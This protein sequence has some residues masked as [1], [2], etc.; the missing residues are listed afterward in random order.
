MI[1]II[2]PNYNGAALLP[3]CLD[4]LRRQTRRDFRTLVVDDGSTDRSLALLARDYPE[5]RVLA[6][7]R[8]RGMTGA[9]NAALAAT[10]APFVVLLNNDTEA[11]PQWLERL[12]GALERFP[13]Y[14][15]AASKM[16]LFDRRDHLHSAGDF[17]R[18]D[19]VPG[20]RGVWQRDSGQYDVVEEVFGP[21]AG[22]AAYRRSALE[23]LATGGQ[24]LDEDLGMYCEDVDLNL[25]AQL[26]GRRTVYEPRAVIYHRLSATGGGSL[27][28]YYC[29]RNFMLVWA[30][31]MPAPLARRAWPALALSQIG[32]ALHSLWH[33]REKAARAR[34][35]G[36]LAG[37][38]ALPRFWRKRRPAPA[39]LSVE[40]GFVRSQ[41]AGAPRPLRRPAHRV[42]LPIST[43][44]SAVSDL[45]NRPLLSLVIPAYNEERRLPTTLRAVLDYLGRQS[46]PSEVL[47]A[48]DGS[49]DRTAELVEQIAAEHPSV[50][51]LR[52]DHRGKGFAVRAGALAAA[53]R[54]VL[55]CDADLAVPIDEWEKLHQALEGGYAVAI[56]SREGL[57]A[58]RL[59]EPWY[60]H[61]MGRVFNLIVQV[62][63]V[64]GIQ[65]TQCGFKAFTRAAAQDLFQRVRLYGDDAQVVRGA[66]V[67]AFDVEVLFL[68]RKRGYP[69][70]E[71]P[72]LWH[73][74]E[75][76]KVSPLRDS[77]RNF[78]DVLAVRWNAVR[79]RYQGLDVPLAEL[80]EEVRSKK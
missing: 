52:L 70:R 49:T 23:A 72:V 50:R 48:D 8:N 61:L 43:G 22:A 20:S 30:K 5:V 31:N 14:D 41:T 24:V 28:S 7:G 2:I 63:A 33:A 11:D 10:D 54:Y 19:G 73:Y 12:V 76:T 55:L 69:I 59:G 71:V 44:A 64:G 15:F 4:S 45:A 13:Q 39:P 21:C 67:T 27:A 17:Y 78:R 66:A 32:F 62:V 16:R 80:K 77:Y 57:G 3:A 37:L 58:R 56:G 79:G 1:D 36:Q 26:A 53:G 6:L 29:G 75:E 68:A 42:Q 34:L 40:R 51:L 60:R 18:A 25:R 35:R 46:Y 74:G 47:I 65:D 38:R 9:V